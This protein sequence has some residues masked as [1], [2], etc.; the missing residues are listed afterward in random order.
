ME[1]R[2][3]LV[4]SGGRGV[5]KGERKGMEGKDV[6]AGEVLNYAKRIARFTAPAHLSSSSPLPL[7]LPLPLLSSTS[8]PANDN[9]NPATKAEDQSPDQTQTQ[10][11]EL[12]ATTLTEKEGRAMKSLEDFEK[13][14][15]D[16]ASGWQFTPWP[17]EEVL[18]RGGLGELQVLGE[19]GVRA[20][21]EGVEGVVGDG[22]GVEVGG[23][24][25]AEKMVGVR[26]GGR[27]GE[28]GE[29]KKE[30][31]GGLDLY[32]PDEE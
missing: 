14:W 24:G 27:G 30:V 9:N 21:E 13:Q 32:D 26:G 22:V 2:E 23:E 18:R 31:F 16:P 15:L 3:G 29:V 11:Q 5:V 17:S 19:G 1:V 6:T 7:P 20:G 28:G 8:L 4:E 12:E 10:P 25:E